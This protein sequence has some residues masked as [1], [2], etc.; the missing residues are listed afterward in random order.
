VDKVSDELLSLLFAELAPVCAIVGGVL[1]QEVIK[2]IF[3]V[4]SLKIF[5]FKTCLIEG[6]F[7]MVFVFVP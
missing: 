1:A 4:T 6:V 3:F 2:V 5:F 7:L